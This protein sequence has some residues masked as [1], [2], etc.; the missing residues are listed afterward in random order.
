MLNM[1]TL[2]AFVV[3]CLGARIW[4]VLSFVSQQQIACGMIYA[5]KGGDDIY[6]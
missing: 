2:I 4:L 5:Y 3:G 6:T 1:S